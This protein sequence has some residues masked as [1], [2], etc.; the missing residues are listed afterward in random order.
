M[1]YIYAIVNRVNKKAYIGQTV[2][3]PYKRME[4][5]CSPSSGCWA[6]RDAILEYGRENFD[7]LI[8]AQTDSRKRLNELEAELIK[9]FNTVIPNGYNIKAEGGQSGIIYVK[10]PRKLSAEYVKIYK[11]IKEKRVPNKLS[12]MKEIWD[13][14]S[15]N[16]RYREPDVSDAKL[17][18]LGMILSMF[19]ER[20]PI[21]SIKEILIKSKVT[22]LGLNQKWT[23]EFIKD[24]IVKYYKIR[25][26]VID[27]EIDYL[28]VLEL[29]LLETGYRIE[30]T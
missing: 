27:P 11:R 15:L 16:N 5:H 19:Q 22:K 21:E 3:N 29:M 24:M 23:N 6:L 1:Y 4:E 30:T 10:I 9:K 14:R 28:S 20:Y 12:G 8:I 13:N 26:Y 7:F 18:S 2:R 25:E 17:Y